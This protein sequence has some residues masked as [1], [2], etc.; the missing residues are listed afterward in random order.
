VRHD[1]RVQRPEVGVPPQLLQRPGSEIEDQPRPV[2]LNQQTG[3]AHAR[4]GTCGTATQDCQVHGRHRLFI[5]QLRDATGGENWDGV[6]RLR[7]LLRL[8]AFFPVLDDVAFPEEDRLQGNSPL[9][10]PP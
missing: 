4:V 7:V 9:G 1:H 5:R 10:C 2:R 8:L 6:E 3:A